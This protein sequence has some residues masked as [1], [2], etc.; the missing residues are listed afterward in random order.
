MILKKG[1]LVAFEG[2]DGSGK[3]T[4]AKLLYEHLTMKGLEVVLSKEPTDSIYGQKIN[5][6]AQGER[7]LT[8]P[9][10]EYR[11]FI[12]DRKIHLEPPSKVV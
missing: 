4:Q 10:D 5:K 3:T 1:F 11:L 9:L 8:K 6:L 7:D 2:I 12:N